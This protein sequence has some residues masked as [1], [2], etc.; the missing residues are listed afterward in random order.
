M[1]RKFLRGLAAAALAALL[2]T[3][4]GATGDSAAVARYDFNVYLGDKKLG[5]HTFEVTARGEQKV[6]RSEAE[7]V[8]KVLFIPAYRYEHENSER[9][10]DN[11]LLEFD[12]QTYDNGERI[13]ASGEKTGD[14]FE[15]VKPGGREELP[16]CV[17]S[18]AYWNPDFLKEQ[19]LLNPQTGEYLEVTVEALPDQPFEIRGRQIP[20][21]P[22][23]I[24]AEGVELTVWYAA[25]DRRWLGLESV[26]D[27]DKVL[28]Y[29]PA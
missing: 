18:F 13:R 3:T 8:Y 2:A 16:A 25:K 17:M 20:A 5:R 11:C 24:T 4:A 14:G 29:V 28:K 15:V 26:A 10:A 21:Q 9:W 22:Y 7:F 6:V 27:G 23:R 19:R 12:A 1:N